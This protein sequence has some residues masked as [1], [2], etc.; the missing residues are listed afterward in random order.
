MNEILTKDRL[1]TLIAVFFITGIWD[2]VLR[3]MAEG[4]IKFFGIENM[5]W[6]RVLEDYFKEHTVLSAF[7]LAAFVGAIT[8]LLIIYVL[9]FLNIKGNNYK[10]LLLSLLVV[11]IISGLVGIPMRYSGL[12]PV[13]D[14]T[15]Y[16]P[17]GFTYSFIT[18]SIS[19]VIVAIT[20]YVI[21]TIIMPNKL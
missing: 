20:L 16:K 21:K 2:L 12:F 17:L 19:G 4:H 14:D 6:V 18:D 1:L 3:G 15:Y 9:H 5:K 10:S 7:L 11:F 13:L 8:Y